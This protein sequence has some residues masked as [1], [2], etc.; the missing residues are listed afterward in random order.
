MHMGSIYFVCGYFVWYGISSLCF[1]I[2]FCFASLLFGIDSALVYI[3]LHLFLC[4]CHSHHGIN[5]QTVDH[6]INSSYKF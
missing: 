6:K 5:I 4:S 3:L 1:L 2:N